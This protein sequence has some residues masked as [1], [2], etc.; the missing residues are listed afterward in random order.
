[1]MTWW[2]QVCDS[3]AAVVGLFL[4]AVACAAPGTPSAPDGSQGGGASADSA[5]DTDTRSDAVGG[6]EVHV[7]PETGAFIAPPSAP[8]LALDETAARRAR[9]AEPLV[10]VQGPTGGTMIELQGRFDSTLAVERH[11]DRGI[12]TR[13]TQDAHAPGCTE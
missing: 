1:M 10:E 13:C 9:A 11:P 6:L 7:D 8:T 12:A 2:S 3:R 4:F 5:V